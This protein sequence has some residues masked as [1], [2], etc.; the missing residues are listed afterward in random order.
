MTMS[1]KKIIVNV[2]KSRFKSK[3]KI[4]KKQSTLAKSAGST[5]KACK[6]TDNKT[7]IIPN[8]LSLSAPF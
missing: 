2:S 5:E 4:R 3:V 1:L 6:Y 8:N 7:S